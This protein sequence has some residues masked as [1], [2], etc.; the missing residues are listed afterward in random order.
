MKT[1]RAWV[2]L[3]LM[4]CGV[5]IGSFLGL[6]TKDI[7][8]LSWLDYGMTFGIGTGGEG[9][10]VLNLGVISL[11]FGLSIKISIASIIGVVIA[12]LIYRRL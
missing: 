8:W 9:A 4:L 1:G 7:S 12:F 3:L 10:L 11:T 6:L 2:L 5:V